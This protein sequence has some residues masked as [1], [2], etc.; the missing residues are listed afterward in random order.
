M[1]LQRHP[2]PTDVSTGVVQMENV[3]CMRHPRYDRNSAPDLSCKVCCRH[4]VDHILARQNALRESK[5]FDTYKWLEEKTR[6]ST[7]A[8]T[9]SASRPAPLV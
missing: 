5:N 9:E 2:D 1:Q 3:V 8:A 7:G 6:R 4:Y